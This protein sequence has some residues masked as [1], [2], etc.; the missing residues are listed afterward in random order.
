MN[1]N[2]IIGAVVFLF[3][4]NAFV[5]ADV[6]SPGYHRVYCCAKISNISSF[7]DIT[8][9]GDLQGPGG[10]GDCFLVNQD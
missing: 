5:S 9:V 8:V 10:G 3:V 6:I 7:P 1:K 2:F 4:A